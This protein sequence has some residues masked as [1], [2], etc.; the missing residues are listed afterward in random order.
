MHRGNYANFKFN[1]D[2]EA[3]EYP[4]GEAWRNW[5]Y[6][7]AP[8]CNTKYKYCL[9]NATFKNPIPLA[10]DPG[11]RHENIRKIIKNT[12]SKYLYVSLTDPPFF[13]KK[14]TVYILA[15][16]IDTKK[17]CHC[18]FDVDTRKPRKE[19]ENQKEK[20]KE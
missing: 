18:R 2:S 16:P 19:K 15:D 9:I 8:D 10:A 5:K 14:Y 11:E 12:Q 17:T 4:I 13:D 6:G 20:R 1:E 3:L 7:H